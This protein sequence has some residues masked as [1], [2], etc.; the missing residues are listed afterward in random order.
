MGLK[1]LDTYALVEIIDGNPSFTN[2]LDDDF[3]FNDHTLI[4]FY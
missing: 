4:E 3:C 2:Y 1:Y